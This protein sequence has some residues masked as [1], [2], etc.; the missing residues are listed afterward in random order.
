[1]YFMTLP[2]PALAHGLPSLAAT[3]ILS[4]LALALVAPTLTDFGSSGDR[5]GDLR[6]LTAAATCR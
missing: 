5:V 6:C 1:M 4:F 3:F 2:A